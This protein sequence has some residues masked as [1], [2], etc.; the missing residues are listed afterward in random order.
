MKTSIDKPKKISEIKNPK[1]YP[2]GTHIITGNQASAIGAYLAGVQVVAA[3]PITPQSPVVE[4]L[5]KF[6]EDGE[7]NAEFVPVE[8]EHSAMSVCIGAST[9]GARVFTATSANGLAY[10]CEQLHWASGSRLPIVMACVNRAMAAPWSVQNDQQDSMSQ[11]DAGWIQL[12]CKDNQE[13]LDTVIQAFK[14]AE[15][16]Y[17]PVMV[18]YDGYILS[19]T[20]MPVNI[21]DAKQVKNFLPHYKPHTPIEL[22]NP[23]NINPVTLSDPR[24]NAKGLL[25]HGYLEHKY[26][27]HTALR[28]SLKVIEEVDEEFHQEFGR[29]CGGLF[30]SYMLEDAEVVI[31]CAGSIGLLS[32]IAIDMLRNVGVPS[33][34]I[35]L[36]AYRPFP[37]KKISEALRNKKLI[38]TIDKS[39]SYGYQGPICADLK[40]ALYEAKSQSLVIGYI[41]G[42]GGRD[43]KP[44]E[45]A[46]A[47]YEC[48]AKYKSNE[49]T[50]EDTIESK[51]I[52]CQ[53]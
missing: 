44:Y 28:E 52:N 4:E 53:Y 36:R 45:I 35:T 24:K 19:H 42:L 10:M 32:S 51:W 1:S 39:L 34:L 8:S 33:G 7:L 50:S 23:V 31:V 47:A 11:R 2:P 27:H 20:V 41:A 18:C 14:I 43:V 16:V 49:I 5:A 40:S 12:F 37:N 30:S 15:K 13:I 22:N 46:E 21:P 9:V 3:Y 17:L 26:L 38:I 6:I 29:K 48:W 25:C